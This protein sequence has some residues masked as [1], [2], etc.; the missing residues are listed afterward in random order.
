M[1]REKLA[2]KGVGEENGFRWRGGEISRIE[3]F[4]DAVFAFAVT[5]LVV[6]LEVP[7][8]FNELLGAMRGFFAFAICFWLLLT[9]WYNHYIFFRRYGLQDVITVT[10]NSILLFV[11]LFYV[12]PLKFLFTLFIEQ[13]F[14]SSEPT[15]L[16]NGQLEPVI[17]PNQVGLLFAIYGAGFI[18]LS[19]VSAALYFYAYRQRMALK[20]T[21]LELFDTKSSIRSSL[22]RVVVAIV[23]VVLALVGQPSLAG[24]AYF[25]LLPALT[26]DGTLSGRRRRKLEVQENTAYTAIGTEIGSA[27]KDV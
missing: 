22:V 18:A 6:S 15:V 10:L 14:A 16:V 23:S 13:F 24:W 2:E 20:L 12:Y 7:K 21:T 19:L 3:G 9:V 25:L 1:V 27:I 26:I 8:T 4:S 17:E 11:V 5:L